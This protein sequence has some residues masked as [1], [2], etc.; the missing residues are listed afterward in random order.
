MFVGWGLR[1][2]GGKWCRGCSPVASSLYNNV[3]Y[4]HKTKVSCKLVLVSMLGSKMI[5]V[6][7]T[8]SCAVMLVLVSLSVHKGGEVSIFQVNS[9]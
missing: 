2:V 8:I 3:S 1:S 9:Q 7:M 5:V 6:A 4:L